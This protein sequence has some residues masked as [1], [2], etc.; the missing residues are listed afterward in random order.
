MNHEISKKP[1]TDMSR[2]FVKP[3]VDVSVAGLAEKK[4]RE[5]DP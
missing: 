4:T 2:M 3:E 5:I 1:E